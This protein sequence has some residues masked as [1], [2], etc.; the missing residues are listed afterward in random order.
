MGRAVL[1]E[2]CGCSIDFTNFTLEFAESH[3]RCLGPHIALAFAVADPDDEGSVVEED[4][5]HFRHHLTAGRSGS[6]HIRESADACDVNT[7][8]A[9]VIVV[10]VA[11]LR[12]DLV[13]DLTG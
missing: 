11:C 7:A 12:P 3:V 9:V 5:E 10:V 8:A 6:R 2:R 1:R 13:A 4:I